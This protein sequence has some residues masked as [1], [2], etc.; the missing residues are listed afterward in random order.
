MVR[1]LLR[2]CA[3]AFPALLGG[4]RAGY[5]SV[6]AMEH[7]TAGFHSLEFSP[8]RTPEALPCVVYLP[9]VM[10]A[11]TATTSASPGVPAKVPLVVFLHGRG[12]CG[13]DGLRQMINGVPQCIIREPEKWPA[14][15]VMP[16]KPDSEKPWSDYEPQLMA[17]IER[18]QRAWPVDRSRIYLT[19]LSQGG[20]GTWALAAKHPDLFAAIAPV[21]GF[22]GRTVGAADGAAEAVRIGRA[23][24]GIPTWTFHGED[25][26]VVPIAQTRA[27]VA[28]MRAAG[29][30]PRFTAYPG[31]NHGSWENAYAEPEFTTWLFAQ[32]RRE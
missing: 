29:G 22:A 20:A 32:K 17:L 26:S 5:E 13:T 4:C 15:V 21:C 11:A 3:V 14:V 31:V 1:L 25:D 16:Q 30:S 9:R 18:A 12:E 27:I 28:A 24:A 8:G 10:Q 23:V 7:Q 2:A 19:G 6:S